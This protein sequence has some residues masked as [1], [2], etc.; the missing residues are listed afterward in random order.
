MRTTITRLA[1][2]KTPDTFP[3]QEFT[4]EIVSKTPDT[5]VVAPDDFQYLGLDRKVTDTITLTKKTEADEFYHSPIMTGYVST[6]E[7]A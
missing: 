2:K 3:V 7:P 5:L 6:G 4:A 1:C